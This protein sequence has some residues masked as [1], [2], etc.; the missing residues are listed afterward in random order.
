M[1]KL[2]MGQSSCGMRECWNY[3]KKAENGQ[4]FACFRIPIFESP[5]VPWLLTLMFRLT[6]ERTFLLDTDTFCIRPKPL[7]TSNPGVPFGTQRKWLTTCCAFLL[8]FSSM[9]C[10]FQSF[11]LH[12]RHHN[13]F[14]L[15]IC[16]FFTQHYVSCHVLLL[17]EKWLF[18]FFLESDK[19]KMKPRAP[20]TTGEVAHPSPAL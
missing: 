5:Y 9:Q 20:Q 1:I 16:F 4:G 17:F 7:L 3:R 11:L 13:V 18:L 8:I 10:Y 12:G 6:H 15:G 2:R 19:K 14:C